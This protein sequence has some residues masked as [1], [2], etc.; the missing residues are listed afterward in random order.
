MKFSFATTLLLAASMLPAVSAQQNSAYHRATP[1]AKGLPASIGPSTHGLPRSAPN[2]ATSQATKAQGRN[3][4]LDQIERQSFKKS[5]NTPG[6]APVAN[7]KSAGVKNSHSAPMNFAY[8]G[9]KGT[10]NANTARHPN[11]H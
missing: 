8:R 2:V 4:E 6:K 1:K 9:A 7:T 3:R 10:S 11:T 5:G